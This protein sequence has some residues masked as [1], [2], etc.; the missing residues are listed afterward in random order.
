MSG[1]FTF[2]LD[3]ISTSLK[4][5]FPQAVTYVGE[6]KVMLKLITALQTGMFYI[7]ARA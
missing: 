5:Q 6:G 2:L 7:R 4:K 1:F 3:L